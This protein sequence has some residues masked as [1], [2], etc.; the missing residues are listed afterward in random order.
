MEIK[1]RLKFP[2]RLQVNAPAP[3]PG[4]LSIS[5]AYRFST[6]S[7]TYQGASVKFHSHDET[8]RSTSIKGSPMRDRLVAQLRLELGSVPAN[9]RLALSCP[10]L[11]DYF[12]GRHRA[13]RRTAR[14]PASQNP[15]M[16][17]A[18]A[19]YTAARAIG[20]FPVVA[21]ARTLGLSHREAQSWMGA[22]RRRGLLE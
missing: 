2:A 13:P 6:A 5:A 4:T 8:V 16:Q 9:Q 22:A 10:A 11:G 1:D 18:L 14:I 21:V 20:D 15:R 17:D 19:V 3:Q 7:R 12:A